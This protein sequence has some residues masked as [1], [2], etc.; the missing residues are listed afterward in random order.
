MATARK[1]PSGRYRVRIY[2][3]V[4]KKYKSFSAEDKRTAERMA[5]DWLKYRTLARKTGQAIHFISEVTQWR[6]SEP[7]RKFKDC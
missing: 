2:D 7:Q 6:S 1:L 5:S 4:T 3:K